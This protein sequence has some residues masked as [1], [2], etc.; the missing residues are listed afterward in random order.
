MKRV[1]G[2]PDVALI[3]CT[4]PVKNKWRVRWDIATDESGATSYIEEEL[5]HRPSED[6]IKGIISAWINARTDERILSGFVYEGNMVWLSSENQFNYKAAHDLAV[7]TAGA[8]LPATFKLGSDDAPCY[9]TFNDI[10]S[11][12]DF[13]SRAMAHIQQALADGW[14]AKD[15]IDLEKYRVD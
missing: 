14:S 11:L 4:N 13:Y 10:D 1:Q 5:N 3:E 12:T 2:N 6:E 9:R 8:T 7:Q 15:S